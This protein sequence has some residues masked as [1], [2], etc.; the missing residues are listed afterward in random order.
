MTEHSTEHIIPPLCTRDHMKPKCYTMRTPQN[1]ASTTD[2]AK[3][4]KVL[5]AF[6]SLPHI[7][8]IQTHI[9]GPLSQR[10]DSIEAATLLT[11]S[12]LRGVPLLLFLTLLLLLRPLLQHLETGTTKEMNDR[13][14]DTNSLSGEEEQKLLNEWTVTSK[15]LSL[16]IGGLTRLLLG[17]FI[18]L[19]LQQQD[20]PKSG[21]CNRRKEANQRFG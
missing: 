9:M 12:L 10:W 20:L 14:R 3:R 11:R 17:R 6:S 21:S 2:P 13:K 19:Q 15:K 18:L 16:L 1:H 8:P 4:T 5:A 7:Q